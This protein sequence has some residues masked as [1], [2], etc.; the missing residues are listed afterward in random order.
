MNDEELEITQEY[1]RSD[2]LGNIRKKKSQSRTCGGNEKRRAV[3]LGC[4]DN[5]AKNGTEN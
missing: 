5:C 1:I 3:E 2:E 4:L